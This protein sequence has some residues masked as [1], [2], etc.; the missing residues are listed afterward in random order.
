[1]IFPFV[2]PQMF[3]T[4]AI[5]R[6][7]YY[8][9]KI[10]SSVVIFFLFFRKFKI[11]QVHPFIYLVLLFR[12]VTLI[13]TLTSPDGNIVTY[14]G[15]CIYDL[16]FV[17]LIQYGICQDKKQFIKAFIG[18][19]DFWIILN[20]ITLFI[21]GLHREGI[22]MSGKYYSSL[23][24]YDNRYIY[25]FLPLI[26]ARIIYSNTYKGKLR[27]SDYFMYL[28]CL[29]TLLYVNATAA[30]VAWLLFIPF[31]FILRSKK[32][33]K[34][35]NYGLVLLVFLV[36]N[37]LLVFQ[38]IQNQF[39]YIIVDILH[40]DLTL[41][42]RTIIWDRA[43]VSL[44]GKYLIG[45]GYEFESVVLENL[46]NANHTHNYMLML[47]YRGG[48]VGLVLY[49]LMLYL[50]NKTLKKNKYTRNYKTITFVMAITLLLCLFDSFDYTIFYFVMF[51]SC[52][53]NAKAVNKKIEVKEVQLNQNIALKN[54][55]IGQA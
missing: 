24:G 49:C 51:G 19:L 12:L 44:E 5:T 8:G 42:Y 50:P 16:A 3:D 38:R 52:Y 22:E 18:V 10:V 13:P 48:V 47:I 39:E 17:M 45:R 21:P 53:F 41:S 55:S 1:M 28:F 9:M 20:T 7:L 32:K 29:V 2:K 14:V 4:I 23:L 36:I 6:Y 25:F 35:L 27:I 46:N 34:L 33:F 11:N 54:I 31:F 40:K 37:Y 15:I 30:L 43:F 26:F